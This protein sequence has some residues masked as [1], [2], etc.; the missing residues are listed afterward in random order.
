MAAGCMVPGV[1]ELMP[2]ASGAMIRAPLTEGSRDGN[3]N[4]SG[5]PVVVTVSTWRQPGGRRTRPD[6]PRCVRAAPGGRVVVHF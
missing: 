1:D 6:L 5:N 2:W 3:G 4:P